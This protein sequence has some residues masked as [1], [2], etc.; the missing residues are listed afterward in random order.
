MLFKDFRL[1]SITSYI[2]HIKMLFSK[3]KNAFGKL[4]SKFALYL[5]AIIVILL[6]SITIAWFWLNKN[7][8]QDIYQQVGSLIILAVLIGLAFKIHEKQK[9]WFYVA[10]PLIISLALI[11]TFIIFDRSKTKPQSI[12]FPIVL[13]TYQD[14]ISDGL[15][16]NDIFHEYGHTFD[17]AYYSILSNK[18]KLNDIL[19]SNENRNRFYS[20]TVLYSMVNK[21]IG[22]YWYPAAAFISDS[23]LSTP[24]TRPS[25]IS[26]NTSQPDSQIATKDLFVGFHDT[27]LE[28]ITLPRYYT[29]FLPK[30]FAMTIEYTDSKMIGN[31]VPSIGHNSDYFKMF[32]ES[33]SLIHIWDTKFPHL[34]DIKINIDGPIP[35]TTPY[36]ASVFSKN[37]RQMHGEKLSHVFYNK[38]NRNIMFTTFRVTYTARFN[39]L[40]LGHERMQDL[41]S[42]ENAFRSRLRTELD[43]NVVINNL[44]DCGIIQNKDLLYSTH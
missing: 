29:F 19:A 35:E 12:V 40:F 25:G 28:N 26:Y 32:F 39:T 27:Y 21:I 43:F 36:Y 22:M 7:S 5:P 16:T 34:L 3:A 11:A 37:I 41:V 42:W 8:W 18:F 23:N 20:Q 24:F 15:F 38:G 17:R 1:K 14:N 4:F 10:F 31:L 44:V 30:N 9:P 33:A 13:I 6:L 2:T